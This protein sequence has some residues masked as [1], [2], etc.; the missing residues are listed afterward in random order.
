LEPPVSATKWWRGF[1]REGIAAEISLRWLG[2]FGEKVDKTA[3]P[4]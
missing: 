3:G 1:F 4:V 2:V